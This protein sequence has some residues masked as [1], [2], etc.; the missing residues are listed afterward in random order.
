MEI[1]CWVASKKV[2]VVY[3]FLNS[4]SELESHSSHLSECDP[5]WHFRLCDAAL[6]WC[7]SQQ[8]LRMPLPRPVP[9]DRVVIW[10]TVGRSHGLMSCSHFSYRDRREWQEYIYQAD[11]NHPWVGLLRWRQKGLH[12]AGVS[13]HLH[14]HAGYDPSHGHPQDPLQVWAQ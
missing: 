12:Q 11:E 4:A 2:T 9:M 10:K 1:P 3:F 7:S 6:L 13:E 14:G 8:A 5:R